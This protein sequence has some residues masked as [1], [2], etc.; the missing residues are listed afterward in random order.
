M[1]RRLVPALALALALLVLAVGPAG[2]RQGWTATS[3]AWLTSGDDGKFLEPRA[4]CDDGGFVGAAWVERHAEWSRAGVTLRTGRGW[5]VTTFPPAPA[6]MGIAAAAG[7]G[8]G[9]AVAWGEPAGVFVARHGGGAWA[10][11]R[12]APG[13]GRVLDLTSCGGGRLACLMALGEGP[14][15][16]AVARGRS[17]VWVIEPLPLPDRAPR[18]GPGRVVAGPDG[19]PRALVLFDDDGRSRMVLY[20]RQAGGWAAGALPSVLGT[21]AV[22]GRLGL[23]IDARGALQTAFMERDTR[24][25][26]VTD[27]DDPTPTLTEPD[28]GCT[29]RYPQVDLALGGDGTPHVVYFAVTPDGGLQIRLARLSGGRWTSSMVDRTM[30]KNSLATLSVALTGDDR[31]FLSYA[32]GPARAVLLAWPKPD[33]RR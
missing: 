12:L 4:M 3:I 10:I 22:E 24:R 9:P 8:E 33:E 26:L 5:A 14:E 16:L 15:K 17:G 21:A 30:S 7:R 19:R 25:L 28:P 18:V 1:H 29:L 20:D 31:P 27:L 32:L 13:P 2:A 11:D 23:A 6:I